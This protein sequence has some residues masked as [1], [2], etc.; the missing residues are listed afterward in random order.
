MKRYLRKPKSPICAWWLQTALAWAYLACFAGTLQ[1]LEQT[2]VRFRE[3]ART[4]SNIV[5]LGDLIEVIAGNSSSI[6]Q[7]MQLP[8]GPAPRTTS[9]QTWHSADILQHLELRGVHPASV[10]WSGATQTSLRKLQPAADGQQSM[11]P[12]FLQE[13][14]VKQAENLVGQA[15][16]EYISY[17]TGQRVDWVV[18]VLVPDQLVMALQSKRNILSIGGGA[19]PYEGPQK[20]V[21][22]IR[23]GTSSSKI[24]LKATV[25]LPP[26]VVSAKRPLRRGEIVSA[27]AL[28]Y[29]PLPNRAANK[30]AQYF[31]DI[32]EVIGKEV[33][34]ALSTG[35]PIDQDYIGEPVL[36][37]RNALVE[38]QS[39]AG[40]VVVK[41][42]ARSLGSGAKGELIEVEL[43][44]SRQ[45][46]FA[47]VEDSLTVRVAAQASR[48]TR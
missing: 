18:D 29:S 6:K 46:L 28:T 19:E 9:P 43:L 40:S 14:T 37:Q 11:S 25:S 34:R 32:S 10:R 38:L 27:E 3:D 12:A 33:R 41:T 2:V 21:L 7:L 1:A 47:T 39:I 30:N 8:L 5:R 16:R 35:L 22:E 15:I 23:Q 36:I 20:F 45:R 26:M 42:Q 24:S 48:T 4:E 17:K 44:S 31:T 13:R